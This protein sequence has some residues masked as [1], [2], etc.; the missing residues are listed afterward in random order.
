MYFDL[1]CQ[2]TQFDQNNLIFFLSRGKFEAWLPVQ[3][4]S[5]IWKLSKFLLKVNWVHPA[6][7]GSWPKGPFWNQYILLFQWFGK[8]VPDTQFWFRKKSILKSFFLLTLSKTILLLL[9]GQI[10][11]SFCRNISKKRRLARIGK[12]NSYITSLWSKISIS[13]RLHLHHV[14]SGKC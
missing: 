1:S 4:V 8:R 12:K 10:C 6:D 14:N 9:S 7:W 5:K 11:Y 2:K 3:G 13:K